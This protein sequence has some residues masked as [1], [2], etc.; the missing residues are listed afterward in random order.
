MITSKLSAYYKEVS[1]EQL[2]RF[3]E[4]WTQVDAKS[5]NKLETESKQSQKKLFDFCGFVLQFDRMLMKKSSSDMFICLNKS[6][7]VDQVFNSVLRNYMGQNEFNHFS[8]VF[9]D[10]VCLDLELAKKIS[11]RF[12]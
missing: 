6:E 1:E 3:Y 2:Y 8:E 11:D 10:D 7:K 4:S 9:M 5:V 12:I